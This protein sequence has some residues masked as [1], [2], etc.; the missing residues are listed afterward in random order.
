MNRAIVNAPYTLEA[1]LFAGST[2]TDPAPDAATV[3]VVRAD[4]TVLLAAGAATNNTGTGTFARTLTRAQMSLLD[5]L[6]VRWSGTLSGGETFTLTTHV[7]VVGG[8]LCTLGDLAEEFP[9]AGDDELSQIRTRAEQ[10]LERACRQAFVPRYAYET[11]TARKRLRLRRRPVRVIRSL[12][13][14]GSAYPQSTIDAIVWSGGEVYLPLSSRWYGPTAV[15]YEYGHD[16]PDE[17]VREATVL[18]AVETEAARSGSGD[19][20]VIRREADGQAI[21]YAS[22]SSG[23]GFLDPTLRS[24]VRDLTRTLV[25]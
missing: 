18:A 21:T 17:L 10:R 20:R 14:N 3:E 7:E 24:L 12:S 11:S 1:T 13:V 19:G 9:S 4:G 2:A 25:A 8:F 5:T 15:G 6:E 23:G 16:F 22:P